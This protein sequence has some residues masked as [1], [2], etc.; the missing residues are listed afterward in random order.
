MTAP[1]WSTADLRRFIA[2]LAAAEVTLRADVSLATT[3]AGKAV[4]AGWRA[5]ATAS[6]GKHGKL[7]PRTIKSQKPNPFTA[8]IEPDA[9]MPQGGMSF[10]F[11]SR[12]QGPHLDGQ[13]ALDAQEPVYI[14]AI[15]AAALAALKLT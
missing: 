12:N 8:Q 14:S 6:S 7:Y 2:Q 9:G 4:E 10:E 1:I 3:V 5:G 15:E 11:G 13:K